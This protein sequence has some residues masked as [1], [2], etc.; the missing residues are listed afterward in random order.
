MAILEI[1]DSLE[2]V[3][4][5]QR[6][7]FTEVNGKFQ[8]EVEMPDVSGLKTALQKERD[9]AKELDKKLALYKDVDPEK[10]AEL[11]KAKEDGLT[12]LERYDNAI[13][14]QKKEIDALKTSHEAKEKDSAAKLQKFHADREAR[15]AA[16]AAG[17]IPEDIDDVLILTREIR[18]M[19]DD[20]KIILLDADG[21]PTGRTL[22]EYFE[23]DFKELKPKYYPGLPGG[24]GAT[25]GKGTPKGDWHKLSPMERINQ[26][27]S[28]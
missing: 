6:A 4:E 3:E 28:V 26:A 22:K 15:V 23:K 2:K 27:R 8:R 5:G 7:S 25:G 11:L 21:D 12:E 20:G 16:L 18:S 1:I 17:V 10:Y 13:K 14:K 19:D 9:A 24:G